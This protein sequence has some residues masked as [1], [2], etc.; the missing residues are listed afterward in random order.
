MCRFKDDTVRLELKGARLVFEGKRSKDGQ[1]LT[2]DF[3]QAGQTF[4][5]TLKRVAKVRESRR[6]QV[7]QKPVARA[8]RPVRPRPAG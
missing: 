3:K 8:G 2:G 1:E 7:P 6:P 4:P 5:L